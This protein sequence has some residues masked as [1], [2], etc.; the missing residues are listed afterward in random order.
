[1]RLKALF[2]AGVVLLTAL[3]AQAAVKNFRVKYLQSI[4]EDGNLTRNTQHSPFGFRVEIV[5]DD[6]GVKSESSRDGRPFVAAEKG[7]RYSVRLYNPLP[8]RV[9]VNLTVDGL[10]SIS[11]KP[12]GV[13]DGQ[14]WI[15]D[16]YGTITIPGWQ[17]SGGEA[18][19]FFF[20][21]KP[22]T[23]AKWMG[24]RT[25]KDLAA[26]CGVIGAAY[27][28]DQEELDRYYADHPVYRYSY[29]PYPYGA[30]KSRASAQ[31]SGAPAHNAMDCAEPRAM[32][33][34]KKEVAG[35]GMGERESHP[36]YQVDFHYN[37]GMYDAA[38]AVVIYYDFARKAS[39]N[40]FPEMSFAPEQPLR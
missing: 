13:S 11:G 15:I 40:P 8:V 1:M 12:S 4:W 31:A 19:R 36:T 20:T 7:E 21:D 22:K 39:P 23:Y 37:T 3:Q 14:K 26:N 5:S 38:Q 9:A 32:E 16:P 35:T 30:L 25:G 10:N 33:E 17:V 28:W 2:A 29:R 24:D 27:F 6:E 18:R 34:E